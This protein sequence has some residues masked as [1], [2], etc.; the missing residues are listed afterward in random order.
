MAYDNEKKFA[1]FKNDKGDNAARPD[2]RGEFTL[3]GVK[4][5]LSGW[6]S[7]KKET[8]EKYIRGSLEI[9]KKAAPPSAQQPTQST[10][11]APSTPS[12]DAPF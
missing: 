3:N 2:Y 9:D 4:Y 11:A 5:R 10:P 8:K 12:E 1:L 6:I 7:E